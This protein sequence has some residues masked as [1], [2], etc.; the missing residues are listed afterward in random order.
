MNDLE[1][2]L[3]RPRKLCLGIAIALAC[4]MTVYAQDD[5]EEAEDQQEQ[6]AEANNYELDDLVVT[7][8]R[9]KRDTYTSISPVQVIDAQISREVGLIDSVEILQQ[10]PAATGQQI[11]L[12]FNGFVLDNGP[13]AQTVDLRGL[14]ADRTLVL[15]DG[16]RIAPAGVEGAPSAAD[17]SLMPTSLID[18]Y[19]LLLDGA[20]SV[21]G[22]DAVAGVANAILRKDFNGLE[23]NAFHNAPADDGADS[24]R[25][26]IT[27]GKN[28]DRGFIGAGLEFRDTERMRIR[29]RDFLRDCERPYEITSDGTIRQDNIFDVN[30]NGQ[31]PTDGCNRGLLA[32]RISIPQFGSVYYQPGA[33]NAIP[34]FSESGLFSVPVDFDGDGFADVTFRD[35]GLNGNPSYQ[36]SDLYSGIETEHF[37]SYGEYT[38][39]GDA[40]ITPFFEVMYNTRETEQNSG[41]GQ[42]FPI[43]P[44][45]NPFNPCN[46]NG[47]N[48]VDCGLAF[49]AFLTN[50]GYVDDFTAFYGISHT[51]FR[52]LGIVD[53]FVGP[54]GPQSVQPIVS[55]AGDR[56]LTTTDLD[57][58]RVVAGV[59]GDF[60]NLNF[61]SMSN[62]S[63][64]VAGVWSE[65]DGSSSR[66]GVRQDRLNLSLSTTIEDPNNPGNFI[67]GADND[68]DGIPDGTDGC[69]PINLFAPSLY[70]GGVT[71]DLATQAERDY[72]FDTRD[73]RTKYEQTI[74]TAYMSGTLFEM[75]A[76]DVGAVFGAE[77]R[78]D[79]IESIPDDVARDGLFFGFFSDAGAVGEKY[80]R[81]FFGEIE[82]P[83]LADVPFATEVT[84]NLSARNTKDELYGSDTTYSAKLGWRPVESL[85]LR[86][87]Y[88]TSFRA[89]NLRENFLAG[90]T[91]FLTLFDPCFIP[92]DALALGGAYDP[93]LDPRD[94][95]VLRNCAANGADP[96]MLN[97]GGNQF[98][99]TEILGGGSFDL[100]PETSDSLSV[101]FAFDQ[102]WFYGFD[103][104]IGATYYD[105][106]IDDTII[107][108]SAQFIIND[109]Y[110][111]FSGNSAFCSRITRDADGVLD[112][113]DSGFI[114][115]DNERVR[116]VDV[117]VNYD[118][119]ITV[120]GKAVAIG[121]DLNMNHPIEVSQTFIDDEGNVDFDNDDGEFGFPSWRGTLNLRAQMDNLVVSLQTRY[122]GSVNQDPDG[123]DP[124]SDV[125][126]SQ[127]T[128]F[129]GDTCLGP[130]NGDVLCRD[131]GFASNYF[132]HNLS[133]TYDSNGDWYAR[134]GVRN[135]LDEGPPRVDGN[136]VLSISNVPI[137]YGYDL[138]GRTYFVDFGINFNN[139]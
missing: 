96:T 98:F 87:T 10:S 137:G 115:R 116:G 6:E 57:Q 22:S 77:Y 18:S 133:A 73:F 24:S 101:G 106:D 97:N 55:V 62:W 43:V 85:L 89:P 29:D 114:N 125:F 102:P 109:C 84:L 74:F 95:E 138:I 131:V 56:N 27:W 108:P 100:D 39:E 136:E 132:T 117:N 8:S 139:F 45:N 70:P 76:G 23:L 113:V 103:L 112:I 81:E 40:N 48:G 15:I 99:S 3:S 4:S 51:D 7:G 130:D 80:T 111:S 50:P 38:F 11:D 127:G 31:R 63:W 67:C 92:E 52:D 17:V 20:S 65:S 135:V 124:L 104:S 69:V 9:L 33:G 90:Q 64:E 41:E 46:P 123:V 49:D 120:F 71:G 83:L 16:R 105:I 119:D 35:Y 26:S 78:E 75:P 91:G 66:P 121:A 94:A 86:A 107:E 88:G 118:Q 54:L 60:P 110:N 5:S 42:L 47:V 82:L 37:M 59:K 19:E 129:V 12:T 14:G 44:A 122:I 72:L 30:I 68:G 28:F 58:T 61:G 1:R 25:A 34:N 2:K 21:Y 36:N 93:A 128:G 79:E 13:G 126:D 53:L 32:G 134:I